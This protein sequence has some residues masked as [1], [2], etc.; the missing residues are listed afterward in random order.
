MELSNP[1]LCPPTVTVRRN[2]HRKARQPPT[3][4]PFV[5]VEPEPAVPAKTT[6]ENLRVYLRIRPPELA[7]RGGPACGGG[8]TKKAK[9]NVGE[10]SC[11]VAADSHS[12]VL[13]P[14]ASIRETKRLKQEVFEGF[15]R[16]F[17]TDSPQV[18]SFSSFDLKQ[19]MGCALSYRLWLWLWYLCM[20][21][22]SVGGDL[23]LSDGTHGWKFSE[24]EECTIGGYG[25]NWLWEDTHGIRDSEGAGISTPS[26]Q[27]AFRAQL[28]FQLFWTR[29]VS[30][31]KSC[32]SCWFCWET[33][34]ACGW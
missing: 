14:P 3:V 19:C 7:A 34:V 24:T 6:T 27:W 22:V 21:L 11:L 15:G 4:I 33:L 18:C 12:V 30:V 23:C 26:S 31:Q 16:V 28:R 9:T 20:L 13:A 2:P 17:P 25:P 5:D 32:S 10:E 29:K 1:P 8:K